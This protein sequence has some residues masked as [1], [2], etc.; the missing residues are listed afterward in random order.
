MT[1]A[2]KSGKRPFQEDSP[3]IDMSLYD[4]IK[5]VRRDKGRILD[6][7][8]SLSSTKKMKKLEESFQT[9]VLNKLIKL[10]LI[11]IHDFSGAICFIYFRFH[12]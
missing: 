5:A 1:P 10:Y 2:N 6:L 7:V 4:K 9:A 11:S 3:V 12:A 8:E